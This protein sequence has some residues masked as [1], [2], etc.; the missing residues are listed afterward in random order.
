MTDGGEADRKLQAGLA[1]LAEDAR[2]TE[3]CPPAADIWS[4]LRGEL[5]ADRTRQLGLHTVECAACAELWRLARHAGAG[6]PVQPAITGAGIRVG[7]WAAAAAV[8]VLVGATA[9]LTL[10][11]D[12]PAPG[13]APRAPGAQVSIRSLVAA[14]APL[15]RAEARLQ[16]VGPPGATFSITVT[17][18]DLRPLVAAGDLKIGELLLTGDILA[19]LPDGATLLWK[20]DARLPDGRRISRAFSSTLAGEPPP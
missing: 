19:D 5:A 3:A 20:V 16:W 1:A 18:G 13:P 9:L 12:R 6:L 14:G 11:R 17:T 2:P 8:V 4:A 7:R 10:Q 15:P